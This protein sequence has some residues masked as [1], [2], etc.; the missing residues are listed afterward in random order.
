MKRKHSLVP[1][2]CKNCGAQAAGRYCHNCGQDIFS[3]VN[4]SV[5]DLV[6]NFVENIFVLDNKLFVTL[7]Y[8]LFFPGRLTSEYV[9]GKV[10]SYVHPSKLFWFIA[11]LFFAL[12]TALLS[13]ENNI[14]QLDNLN[15]TS[16]GKKIKAIVENPPTPS[17][18]IEEIKD[19]ETE[20]N[21]KSMYEKKKL[22]EQINVVIKYAPYFTFLMIPFFA[23]L[24]LIFFY[25]RS[26]YYV[27][28]LTFALHFHSFVFLLFG[29][30]LLIDH[31]FPNLYPKEYV[32]IYIPGIYLLIALYIFYRPKIFSLL[33]K[34]LFLNIIYF[35]G[36]FTLAIVIIV[37]IAIN[38][39]DNILNIK[40][41]VSF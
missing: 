23:L 4:R 35:I 26:Y 34:A 41:H 8:L 38:M 29:I 25:K 10:I 12:F 11:I 39:E 27:D 22:T 9:K 37:L 18:I 13:I 17:E 5:R 21:Y 2:I 20:P 33:W 32:Y 14:D 6:F 30:H 7:K 24:L 15:I 1:T 40:D 31:Y 3:G 19:E 16:D 36:V 28:H